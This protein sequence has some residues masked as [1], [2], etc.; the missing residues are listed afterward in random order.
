MKKSISFITVLLFV[1]NATASNVAFDTSGKCE[2]EGI[3]TAVEFVDKFVHPCV[4]KRNCPVGAFV[5]RAPALY[6][7]TVK[8]QSISC[9]PGGG[10]PFSYRSQFQLNEENTI[11]VYQSELKKE[12]IFEVDDTIRGT[13]EFKS[14]RDKFT[15]YILVK[16]KN[17]AT[18]Q[19]IISKEKI[20]NIARNL[21]N[22]KYLASEGYNRSDIV[23]SSIDDIE[24][25]LLS[26]NIVNEDYE[27][28]IQVL[29]PSNN[30][31]AVC[32]IKS[33]KEDLVFLMKRQDCFRIWGKPE[34]EEMLDKIKQTLA[35][36]YYNKLD[37]IQIKNGK[38]ITPDD[39]AKVNTL[40]NDLENGAWRWK[41]NAMYYVQFEITDKYPET[42]GCRIVGG[43]LLFL[44]TGE[45]VYNEPIELCRD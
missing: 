44:E 2:I 15:D 6:E 40:K 14:L 32:P 12:D 28:V 17:N 29:N 43:E 3:I 39:Q 7:L 19:N 33:N 5:E 42:L 8:I 11:V 24:G 25:Y 4:A 1:G 10:E 9:T 26:G 35:S 34:S 37:R 20:M 18:G 30:L 22:H 27:F 31:C 41:K 23:S 38:R 16:K 36:N 13:V 45:L 21:F